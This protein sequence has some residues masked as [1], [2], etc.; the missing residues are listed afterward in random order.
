[1]GLVHTMVNPDTEALNKMRVGQDQF[2]AGN[3]DLDSSSKPDPYPQGMSSA[4]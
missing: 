3:Q 1:M 2:S 4:P